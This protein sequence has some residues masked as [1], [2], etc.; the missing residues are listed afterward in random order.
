MERVL[1]YLRI[2][3]RWRLSRQEV[4]TY[5]QILASI[6][7]VVAPISASHVVL[8]DIDD[9][10]IVHTAVAGRAEVLCTR[11]A[12]FHEE[13]VRDFCGRRSIAI[14]DDAELLRVIRKQTRSGVCPDSSV[15]PVPLPHDNCHAPLLTLNTVA[16]A[17]GRA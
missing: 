7:E 1:A 2:E 12:H 10:P 4:E 6:S 5:L 3:T 9:D 16:R 13:S 17:Q 15:V 14:M 8:K 11:D